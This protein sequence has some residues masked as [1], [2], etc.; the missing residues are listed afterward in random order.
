[1][2][3]GFQIS[4]NFQ[5]EP[6]GDDP[7]WRSYFS[8]GLVQPPTRSFSKTKTVSTVNDWGFFR[9]VTCINIHRIQM[10]HVRL[11]LVIQNYCTHVYIYIYLYTLGIQN[12]CER[13]FLKTPSEEGLTEKSLS[14]WSWG[15]K[16]CSGGFWLWWPLQE[17]LV[18]TNHD[19]R[20]Y[21]YT[22]FTLKW[23]RSLQE[24]CRLKFFSWSSWWFFLDTRS[25][26]NN[27]INSPTFFL[28]FVP[29][30]CDGSSQA[31]FNQWYVPPY[32]C[33]W[34]LGDWIWFICL[35]HIFFVW[36]YEIIWSPILW[37]RA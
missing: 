19:H 21:I 14:A 24:L 36:N 34:C 15:P 12:P 6:W 33:F 5:P 37:Y 16:P 23:I 8:N 7:I 3:G 27:L 31:G 30:S 9:W 29:M 25:V 18:T 2:G 11:F 35:E 22:K 13:S 4:F 26:N 1:M 32:P 17:G 28:A 20:T 10:S